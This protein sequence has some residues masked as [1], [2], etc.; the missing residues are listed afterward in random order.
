[1]SDWL[2]KGDELSRSSNAQLVVLIPSCLKVGFNDLS[3]LCQ[4]LLGLHTDCIMREQVFNLFY[5]ARA[6]VIEE[7]GVVVHEAEGTDEQK[8]TFL[9]AL[10]NTDYKTCRRFPVPHRNSS[11]GPRVP[12]SVQSYN[13]LLR[14]GRDLELFEEIFDDLNASANPLYCV[15]G[16]VAGKP[17]IDVVVPSQPGFKFLRHLE[18]PEIGGFMSDY[19]EDYL[20][21]AGLDLPAL[22]NDD[23]FTAIRLCFNHRQ[24]VSCMKLIASFIDTMAFLEYGDTKDS[25]IRWLDAFADLQR[26]GVS[27]RQ[28]WE[29][30]NSILHMSNLDSRKVLAGKEARI[31][32]CVAP[33]GSVSK[34]DPETQYFN[35]PDLIEVLW[36]ALSKWFQFMN[37]SREHF[38]TFIERYDRVVSDARMAVT[39]KA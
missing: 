29:F 11:S 26:L 10:V 32:F 27:A 6:D 34:E 20:T 13:A 18:P 37:T 39:R 25:F 14:L 9:Q 38:P 12:M 16:I 4:T 21:P 3:P 30:R 2:R 28:L 24:Y 7:L 36:E 5:F 8:V 1:M 22:I 17:K 15:T 31:S 35:L 33:K 19:L 23:Y